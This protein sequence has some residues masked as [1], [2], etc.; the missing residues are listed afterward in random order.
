MPTR[1]EL[2]DA[3]E[4]VIRREGL[5]GATTRAIAFEAGCSEGSLYN[6][7]SDK[8]DLIAEVMATRLPAFIQAAKELPAKSGTGSV[9]ANLLEFSELAVEFYRQIAPMVATTVANPE[10]RERHLAVLREHGRGPHEPVMALAEYLQAEQRLGRVRKRVDAPVAAALLLGACFQFA[11]F[12]L[13]VPTEL[14]PFDA[15]QLTRGAVKTLL[16]GL[17]PETQES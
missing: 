12:T 8:G 7:F 16:S 10:L 3:A 1:D 2:L 17:T 11:F 4:R 15:T 13:G 5:G 6:H 9:R 14:M